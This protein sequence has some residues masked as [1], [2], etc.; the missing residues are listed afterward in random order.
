M[1]HAFSQNLITVSQL[2]VDVKIGTGQIQNAYNALITGYSILMVLVFLFLI[3][4]GHLI[5]LDFV[6]D[7]TKDMTLIM[8]LVS[9]LQQMIHPFLTQDAKFGIGKRIVVMYVLING[10]FPKVFVQKYQLHA[11][12]LMKRLDNAHHAILDMIL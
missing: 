2:M 3:N 11:R 5:Q 4:A 7:A 12:H 6:L 8:E 10:I 9:F 1:D